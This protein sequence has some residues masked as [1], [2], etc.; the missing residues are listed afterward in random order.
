MRVTAR[1]KPADRTNIGANCG[2][3]VAVRSLLNSQGRNAQTQLLD[4]FR[5]RLPT[6]VMIPSST[7]ELSTQIEAGRELQQP[8]F[9]HTFSTTT[10]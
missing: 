6:N 4:T 7:P 1:C 3:E 2:T 5:I 10:P 9:E 8:V